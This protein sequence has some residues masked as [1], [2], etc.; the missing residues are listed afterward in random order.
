MTKAMKRIVLLE[1][2]RRI[3]VCKDVQENYADQDTVRRAELM[4]KRLM[5]KMRALTSA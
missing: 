1:I 5:R 3:D 2:Q 4:E